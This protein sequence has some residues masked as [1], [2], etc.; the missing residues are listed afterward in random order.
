MTTPTTALVERSVDVGGVEVVAAAEARWAD[1][2]DDVLASFAGLDSVVE[3]DRIQRG[4]GWFEM[5]PH[6]L[7]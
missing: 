7:A 3:G 2:L 5:A 1:R 6:E 4:W